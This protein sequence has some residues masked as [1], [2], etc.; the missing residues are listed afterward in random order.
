M[1]RKPKFR[2]VITRVKLNPEQAVLSCSCY[3]MG[4]NWSTTQAGGANT[5]Y[6]GCQGNVG[7]AKAILYLLDANI[8][9]DIGS[10]KVVTYSV[11]VASS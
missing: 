7:G 2:P 10:E 9:C 1:G 3:S 5:A 4:Y 6:W 11:D 8:G